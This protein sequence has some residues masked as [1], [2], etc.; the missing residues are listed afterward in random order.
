MIQIFVR[1]LSGKTRV[2][3]V[4]TDETVADIKYRIQKIDQIPSCYLRL[5]YVGKQLCDELTLED[6]DI[7]QDSTL[8]VNSRLRGGGICFSSPTNPTNSTSSSTNRNQGS[9]RVSPSTPGLASTNKWQSS[10]RNSFSTVNSTS[11]NNN[12]SFYLTSSPSV[13]S[14]SSTH[15]SSTLQASKPTTSVSLYQGTGGRLPTK[16][17]ISL[18]PPSSSTVNSGG[19]S[20][21]KTI[22]S[23]STKTTSS[24]SLSQGTRRNRSVNAAISLTS[25]S[26]STV[27]A[28]SLRTNKTI[29]STSTKTTPSVSLS[30]RTRGNRSV[31]A[32]ISLTPSSSSTVSTGSLRTSKA[33]SST[34]TKTARSVKTATSLTPSSTVN[35]GSLSTNKTISSTS[36]STKN[37][38][39]V[40]LSQGTGGRPSVRTVLRTNKTVSSTSTKNVSSVSLSQ[41]TGG[42]SSARTFIS[43]TP[44]SSSSVNS[45]GLRTNKTISSTS[46]KTAPSVSSSQGT[47][48]RRPV[49]VVGKTPSSSSFVNSGGLHTNKTTSSRPLVYS[50]S[51][52]NTNLNISNLIITN[53]AYS[54]YAP[55][56][57]GLTSRTTTIKHGNSFICD[58]G[59]LL[60]G[61]THTEWEVV[62][63]YL[64]LPSFLFSPQYDY[65]FTNE[66]DEGAQ[67]T[68]GHKIY[69]RPHGFMRFALNIEDKYPDGNAWLGNHSERR[70]TKSIDE[71]WLVSYHGTT[72][73]NIRSIVKEGFNC[74][75][76][77]RDAF[78]QNGIYSSPNIDVAW[79]YATSFTVNGI[80][81]RAILQNRVNPKFVREVR[82]SKTGNGKYYV[83]RR[84]TD[85]RPYGICVKRDLSF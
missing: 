11:A 44:S 41:G 47:K 38:P 24:V 79:E 68:R 64:A 31:N 51:T 29:S 37:A 34:S 66:Y 22:S 69:K 75:K 54:Y 6:Y 14:L 56:N 13:I 52:S 42:R 77:V 23:T 39:S 20:T 60:R 63:L 85:I 83:S 65:D 53:T 82:N 81:Y 43:L 55:T 35:A 74:S 73:E 36:T 21:N 18:I 1:T 27:N 49:N 33:I 25:S 16:T 46:I 26:S 30:Q 48:G 9:S 12:R 80:K 57:I 40:S 45:G 78:N 3:Q 71:E 2:I 61:V 58:N 28:G 8:H 15:N 70:G 17:V 76:C 19:L 72:V 5:L 7:Q 4:S 32:A 10:S 67:H 50:P 84:S 62:K 59:P